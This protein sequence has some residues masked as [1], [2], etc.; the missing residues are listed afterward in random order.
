ML[1]RDKDSVLVDKDGGIAAAH[2]RRIPAALP[3]IE[4]LYQ[5]QRPL[6]TEVV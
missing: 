1:P 4:R 5:K 2:V 3:A 6:T